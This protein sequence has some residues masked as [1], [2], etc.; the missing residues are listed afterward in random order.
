[1]LYV[2][3]R[4]YR[5]KLTAKSFKMKIEPLLEKSKVLPV[6]LFDF[7]CIRPLF[8]LSSCSFLQAAVEYLIRVSFGTAL[9]ASIVLVY[10][11][12]ITIISSRRYAVIM[13]SF[14]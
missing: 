12:I 7:D 3:S 5:S 2:F 8:L 13:I 14:M 9:I 10:T 6:T 1:M 11:T 4:D